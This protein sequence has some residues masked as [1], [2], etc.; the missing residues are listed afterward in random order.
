MKL[1]LSKRKRGFVLFEVLLAFAILASVT[2]AFAVALNQI[3]EL[4]Q[5]GRTES[6]VQRILDSALIDAAMLPI[7]EAESYDYNL[8][9]MGGVDI[10]VTIEPMEELETE[11]GQIL[12]GLMRV[13]VLARYYQDGEPVERRAE[14]WRNSRLYQ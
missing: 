9:E 13:Q 4:S 6:E 11:Q 7:I 3:A 2:T 14:I 5:F 8:N 1:T 10:E 12:T